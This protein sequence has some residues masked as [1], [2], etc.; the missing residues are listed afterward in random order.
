MI[1]W[2][3]KWLKEYGDFF[4]FILFFAVISVLFKLINLL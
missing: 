2:F 4:G 3:N 1:A